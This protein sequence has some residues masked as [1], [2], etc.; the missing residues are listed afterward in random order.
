MNT[1][2]KAGGAI[3]ED[4]TGRRVLWG[5]YARKG[6]SQ[7]VTY[8]EQERI[9]RAVEAL[10]ELIAC[11]RVYAGA[12]SRTGVAAVLVDRAALDAADVRARELLE[13]L[14]EDPFYEGQDGKV[15][16]LLNA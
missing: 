11:L 5:G 9:L 3:V 14:G 8:E 12:T 15:S 10:P 2:H 13:R 1:W 4:A 7:R 16:E 6:I